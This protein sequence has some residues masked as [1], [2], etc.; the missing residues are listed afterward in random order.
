M[1]YNLSTLNLCG[2]GVRTD[3]WTHRFARVV[4]LLPCVLVCVKYTYNTCA[5]PYWYK[6]RLFLTETSKAALYGEV[7]NNNKELNSCL[8]ECSMLSLV[9]ILL[10]SCNHRDLCACVS[11]FFR[12]DCQVSLKRF[13]CRTMKVK[14]GKFF[15]WHLRAAFHIWSLLK[16]PLLIELLLNHIVCKRIKEKGGG[17]ERERTGV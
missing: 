11:S 5:A 13:C 9:C 17:V 15:S 8:L 14:K 12:K 10:R 2:S 4:T 7:K 1:F 3:D 6:E 16:T